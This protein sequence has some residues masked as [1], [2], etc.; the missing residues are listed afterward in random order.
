MSAS[1]L[2]GRFGEQKQFDPQRKV[3]RDA[4]RGSLASELFYKKNMSTDNLYEIPD[5]EWTTL[6]KNNIVSRDDVADYMRAY[7]HYQ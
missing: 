1:G 7:E 3:S 4:L 2:N 5:T 6:S